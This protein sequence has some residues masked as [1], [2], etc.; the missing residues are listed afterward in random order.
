MKVCLSCFCVSFIHYSAPHVAGAIAVLL[1]KNP[2]A[3]R[4]ELATALQDS[5]LKPPID[6]IVCT[7]GGVNA[8]NPWPNNSFGHGKINLLKALD[9]I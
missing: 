2:D 3:T 7:G 9:L 5:A 8:T 4:A 6:T 1:E